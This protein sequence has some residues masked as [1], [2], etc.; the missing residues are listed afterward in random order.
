MHAHDVRRPF[1]AGRT[2]APSA[3]GRM[4]SA[5][6]AL[7]HSR[8]PERAAGIT[9]WTASAPHAQPEDKYYLGLGNDGSETL[10][11]GGNRYWPAVEW[12]PYKLSGRGA[13]HAPA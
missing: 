5:A 9:S 4:T 2:A 10:E 13:E 7:Q 6:L 11:V 1:A 12:P 3:V 8:R